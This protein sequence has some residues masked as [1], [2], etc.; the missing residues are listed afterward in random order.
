MIQDATL[1]HFGVLTSRVHM[2]WMR[3]V[4]GRLKSDYRYSKNIVYN[5]FV[6][7]SPSPEQ[8]AKIES[9]AQK[10]LEARA[11][12]GDS[13]LAAMYDEAA[14]PLGLRLAHRENDRAVCEAYGWSEDRPEEEIVDELF[15]KYYDLAGLT[16]PE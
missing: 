2:G 16:W 1:Y 13:S 8:K 10:I 4:C 11:E 5:T 7:P 14:I 12:W 15:R 6:W 9:A 3:R